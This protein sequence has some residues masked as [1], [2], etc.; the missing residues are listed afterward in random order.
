MADGQQ[1]RK[2]PRGSSPGNLDPEVRPASREPHAN[3]L[4]DV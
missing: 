1:P 2:E 4:S 3:E